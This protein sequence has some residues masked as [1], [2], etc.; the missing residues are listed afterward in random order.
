MFQARARNETVPET[1]SLRQEDA[2]TAFHP[3]LGS[4]DFLGRMPIPL[5]RPFRSGLERATSGHRLTW[6]FL[7]GG[8]WQAPFDRI[9][10]AGTLNDLP[11]MVVTHWAPDALSAHL[12]ATYPGECPVPGPLAGPCL[13][14]GLAD[15]LGVFTPFAVIPLVFL[16]DHTRLGDRPPPRCWSDLLGPLYRGEVV[17]GGWRPRDAVKF[18]DYNQLLLLGLFEDFGAEGLRAFA[19]SVKTLRHN[20]VSSRTAGSGDPACGAVTIL[21]WMQAA[22]APRRGRVSVV[23]PEDGAMAMPVGFVSRPDRRERLRPIVDFLAGP[24]LAATLTHNCYPPALSAAVGAYPPGAKLKW[25]GW[26]RIRSHDM[27]ERAVAAGRLFF[28][29]WAEG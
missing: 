4:L 18:T 5:R 19:A 29:S 1:L 3:A 11:G 24:D 26:E 22:M 25:L 12:L 7:M 15:P 23:W 14:A 10:T 20:V 2:A 13:E 16:V 28:E 8:E 9:L 17:F 27:A 6:N 21:P